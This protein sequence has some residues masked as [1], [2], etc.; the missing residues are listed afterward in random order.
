[1]DIDP[2]ASEQTNKNCNKRRFSD[3]QIKSLELMFNS[4]SRP[5]SKTKQRIANQLGLHPRQ[6]SVWFQN[7]R[8][9]SKSKQ[10]ERDYSILKAH[11]DSLASKFEVLKKENQTL[12]IEV[13]RL[14]G[15]KERPKDSTS[16]SAPATCSS[17]GE[18]FSLSSPEKLIAKPEDY[19]TQDEILCNDKFEEFKSFE[20]ETNNQENFYMI[21]SADDSLASSRNYSSVE[22]TY[23]MEH[24][25]IPN[26][27]ELWV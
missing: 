23:L 15:L 18:S 9:R 12:I 8:A 16:D 14:R 11:Y 6:V 3:E 13:Q 26:W 17:N 22:P 2:V 27:W 4:E 25:C 5:G 19:Y 10:T 21:E 1:M 7:R 20:Q 24:N